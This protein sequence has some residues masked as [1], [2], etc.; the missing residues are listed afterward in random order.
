MIRLYTGDVVE[1]NYAGGSKPGAKR[2]V[3]VL[4]GGTSSYVRAWDFDKGELRTFTLSKISNHRYLSDEEMNVISVDN[5]PKAVASTITR[6]FNNEGWKTYK[7]GDMV[8]AVK[9]NISIDTTLKGSWY[10]R[11]IS[12]TTK[13]GTKITLT[14]G[15][16]NGVELSINDSPYSHKPTIEELQWVL[17]T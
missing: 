4:N 2:V 14:I 1:F 8:V 3:Y 15:G 12:C 11:T 10:G 17:S 9:P 13:K 6:D 5:L 7:S 16:S